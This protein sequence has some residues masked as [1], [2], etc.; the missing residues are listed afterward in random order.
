[1]DTANVYGKDAGLS[2]E[3]VGRALKGRRDKVVLATKVF[4]PVGEGPND[5]GLSRTHIMRAAEESLH[6]LQTDYI[7]LY[8]VHCLDEFT[9]LEEVLHTLNSLV[10]SG[11]VRYLGVSNFTARHLMK[12][13]MS[14]STVWW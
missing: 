14:P 9:S 4:F 10:E 5:R 11:K 3:I 2:E 12:A 6:R 7:D 8:Y 13:L 1:M